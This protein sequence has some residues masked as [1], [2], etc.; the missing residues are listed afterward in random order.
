MRSILITLLLLAGSIAFSQRLYQQ[1]NYLNQVFEARYMEKP[2]YFPAGKDSLQRFYFSHFTAFDTLIA[3]AVEKG[4]T[5]KYIRIY[6]SFLLDDTGFPYE[7]KFE[8][9]ASTRSKV[10]QSAKTIKHFFDMHDVLQQAIKQMIHKMPP[11]RPG[12][13]DA[14]AVKTRNEDYLQI[15]VGVMPPYE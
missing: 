13:Q 2:P 15:W 1:S 12:I 6:F 10:T 14:T 3:K 8:R 7:P 9:V 11:W 4:D 5:A